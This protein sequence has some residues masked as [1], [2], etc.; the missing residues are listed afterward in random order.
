MANG[1]LNTD[2]P[3]VVVNQPLLEQEE[4]TVIGRKAFL[5]VLWNFIRT[6]DD[7]GDKKGFVNIDAA[8]DGIRKFHAMPPHKS[9]RDSNCAVTQ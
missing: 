5:L 8:A 6:G 1:T 7:G 3:A 4:L 2:V 9:G